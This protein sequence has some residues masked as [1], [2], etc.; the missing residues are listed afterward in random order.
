MLGWLLGR[1]NPG[2]HFPEIVPS[3][4]PQ[5]GG[6]GGPFWIE[7]LSNLQNSIHIASGSWGNPAA[8]RLEKSTPGTFAA[9]IFSPWADSLLAHILLLAA[10]LPPL[11]FTSA[12]LGSSSPPYPLPLPHSFLAH[13]SHNNPFPTLQKS[14]IHLRWTRSLPWWLVSHLLWVLPALTNTHFGYRL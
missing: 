13:L 1:Y 14:C 6:G 12:Q 5:A 3:R 10:L 4:L 7:I 9:F 2:P 8:S 11:H